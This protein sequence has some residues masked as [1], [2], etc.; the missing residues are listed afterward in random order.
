MMG[1]IEIDPKPF[2]G[3]VKYL[4]GGGDNFIADPISGDYCDGMLVFDH[5][6]THR[7]KI[8]DPERRGPHIQSKDKFQN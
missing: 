8:S 6:Y 1:V 4:Q 2:T 3:N 7:K 5:G